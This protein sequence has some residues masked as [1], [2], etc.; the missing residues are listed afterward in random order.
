MIIEISFIVAVSLSPCKAEQ[1]RNGVIVASIVNCDTPLSTGEVIPRPCV[2]VDVP[3][4]PRLI[5]VSI[6]RSPRPRKRKPP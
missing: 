3:A 5:P 1:E 6:S 2:S 4:L